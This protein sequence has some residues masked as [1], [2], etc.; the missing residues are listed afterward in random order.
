[1]AGQVFG[2]AAFEAAGLHRAVFDSFGIENRAGHRV[3]SVM[4]QQRLDADFSGGVAQK[5]RA[6]LSR[7]GQALW[8]AKSP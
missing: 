8:Q 7:C 1:M 6:G 3:L 2:E 5:L 4:P